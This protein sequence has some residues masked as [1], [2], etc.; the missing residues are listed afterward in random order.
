M[1]IKQHKSYLITVIILST[2]ALFSALQLLMEKIEL[3][4]NPNYIPTCSWNPLFSCQGPMSSWQSSVFI[5]PNPV[6]GIVGFSLVILIA[7]TAFFVQH[8][9]W[10]W[11]T[12]TIGTFGAFLFITWLMTQSLYDIQALCIYCM[13]V[14]ATVIPLFWLTLAE[15]LKTYH[16]N[17]WVTRF[18]QLKWLIIIINYF[19][20][21]LMIYLQFPTEINLM[22]KQIF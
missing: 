20:I 3:W 14:W 2:I 21:I 7:F 4:K 19:T 22:V 16:Q 12:Y 17:K 1:L 11:A 15:Y 10:Y 9:K 8:P 5:I 13:I 18:N 6:I